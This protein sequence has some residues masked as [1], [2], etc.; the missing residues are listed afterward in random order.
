M[1][2]WMEG[3]ARSEG[4]EQKTGGGKKGHR[5][6]GPRLE[7]EALQGRKETETEAEGTVKGQ[8]LSGREWWMGITGENFVLA[9]NQ[10]EIS[11][12]KLSLDG[13]S[14][15]PPGHLDDQAVWGLLP[16]WTAW[17]SS[18]IRS[19]PGSFCPPEISSGSNLNLR[20]E[21]L[22]LSLESKL[23][24]YSKSRM[25]LPSK[26]LKSIPLHTQ[27]CLKTRGNPILG[28]MLS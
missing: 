27:F 24:S 19:T 4:K 1:G 14:E 12:T 9:D 28:Q 22:R 3:P 8:G 18:A 20:A 11:G 23:K 13:E 25:T 21:G 17:A 6:M 15:V 16:L 5:G 10:L 7:N 26:S 2:R